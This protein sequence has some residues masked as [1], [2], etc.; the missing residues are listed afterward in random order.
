ML[1]ISNLFI[2]S[3]KPSVIPFKLIK[4]NKQS[5]KKLCMYKINDNHRVALKN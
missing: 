4:P 5:N 3:E 2:L 1:P